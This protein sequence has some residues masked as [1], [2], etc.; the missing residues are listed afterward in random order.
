[1]AVYLGGPWRIQAWDIPSGN[2]LRWT[3]MTLPPALSWMSRSLSRPPLWEWTLEAVLDPHRGSSRHPEGQWAGHRQLLAQTTNQQSRGHVPCSLASSGLLAPRRW[4]YAPPLSSDPPRK[5]PVPIRRTGGKSSILL[6]CPKASRALARARAAH[7]VPGWE[8]IADTS[9]GLAFAY[10]LRNLGSRCGRSGDRNRVDSDD[11]LRA[12]TQGSRP[13]MGGYQAPRLCTVLG[14]IGPGS[15]SD[16]GSSSSR[17]SGCR[18]ASGRPPRIPQR[19]KIFGGQVS[20]QGI[21]DYSSRARV[22]TRS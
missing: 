16:N 9:E 13:E 11:G 22:S 10:G 5:D 17:P 3:A 1:M 15:Q 7:R 19:P 8:S 21:G 12:S 4:R 2:G 20:S 18:K 6:H 14:G